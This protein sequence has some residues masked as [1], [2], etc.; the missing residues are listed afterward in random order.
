MVMLVVV[1]NTLISL[2]LLYV[3]WRVWKLKPLLAF[4]ANRLT[5]YERATHAALQNAPENIYTSQEA[6]YNLRQANLGVQMQIQQVRQIIN[7]L[8]LGQQTWRRYFGRLGPISE[9]KVVVK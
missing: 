1:I 9:K 5:A 6:I 2:I 3:A 8:L 7:L 4:V